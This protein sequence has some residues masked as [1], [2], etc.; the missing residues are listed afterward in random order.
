M[1]EEGVHFYPRMAKTYGDAIVARIGWKSFYLFFHSDHIREVLH[2]KSDVFI[3]GEQYNQLRHLM[4]NG[5]LTSEGRDWEKQRRMLNPI[6]GK[7]GLD[8]LLV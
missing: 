4:G 8:I 5:L 1:K 7:N 2:E 3:K 6:F